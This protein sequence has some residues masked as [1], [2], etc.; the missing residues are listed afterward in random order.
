MLMQRKRPVE[1][2]FIIL[3]MFSFLDNFLSTINSKRCTAILSPI[4]VNKIIVN[5]SSAL[6][7][8]KIRIVL[9]F[10]IDKNYYR[11]WHTIIGR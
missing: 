6:K 10:K 7:K 9:L 5:D 1:V 4:L 3:F 11:V 8:F 2:L